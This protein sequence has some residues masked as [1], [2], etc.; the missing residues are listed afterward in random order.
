M[1]PKSVQRFWVN[2]MHQNQHP[3][4]AARF[5]TRAGRFRAA[6]IARFPWREY[7]RPGMRN[8]AGKAGR[9]QSCHMTEASSLFTDGAAYERLMGRWSRIAGARFL[10]WLDAPVGLRWLDVGCG[11]GAFTEELVARRAPSAVTGVDPSQGQIAYARR[12]PGVGMVEFQVGDAQQLPFDD[13]SFDVATMALVISFVPEPPRAVAEMK[14]VVRP[15][16]RLG[17]YLWDAVANG[18]PLGPV[19]AV[20]R[21]T[22]ETPPAPP[23]PQAS[24]LEP[25]RNLWQAAG[26]DAVETNVIR[27]AVEFAD[28]DDLWSSVD[29]PV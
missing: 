8:L 24:G 10:E 25:L 2:D 20:L 27:I 13:G 6:S 11:N 29:M 23:N 19:A 21:S 9:G 3:K 17:A 22:G 28:F 7:G 18:A 26:L 16:G 5:S 12:R 4:A 1:S 15:G 14:R